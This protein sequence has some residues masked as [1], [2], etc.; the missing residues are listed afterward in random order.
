M[1]G[2]PCTISNLK[3]V[4]AVLV[5]KNDSKTTLLYFMECLDVVIIVGIFIV[6]VKFFA[7]SLLQ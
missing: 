5:F 3:K 2:Y 6:S 4:V 1:D 7:L